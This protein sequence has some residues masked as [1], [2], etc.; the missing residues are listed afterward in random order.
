MNA[1]WTETHKR[2]IRFQFNHTM[3]GYTK[4]Y[5]TDETG[6]LFRDETGNLDNA[7]VIPFEVE[8][9]R[10]NFGSDARKS[11]TAVLSD[12]EAAREAII[13]YAVDGGAYQTLGQVTKNVNKFSFS[14]GNTPNVEGRDISYKL[15][16]S[17]SGDP[18]IINGLSTTYQIQERIVDEGE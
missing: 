12:T 17:D 6:R 9:G 14:T 5:F 3:N 10:N 2:E 1:W 13:Q 7:D 16:H 8:L 15:V 18:P 4:P 11:Y